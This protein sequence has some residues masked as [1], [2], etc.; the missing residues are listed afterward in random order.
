MTAFL[1]V[2]WCPVTRPVADPPK[3]E[4]ANSANTLYKTL[5]KSQKLP[6]LARYK[7]KGLTDDERKQWDFELG[8]QRDG[9]PALQV[10]PSIYKDP[11]GLK[12]VEAMRQNVKANQAVLE[13]IPEA[14]K[15][16]YVANNN[17]VTTVRGIVHLSIRDGILHA[18]DGDHLGAAT[19][20]LNAAEI[21]IQLQPDVY[22]Y[23]GYSLDLGLKALE[24][25][26]AHL[27]P[28]E[29]RAVAQRLEGLIV[30]R[31]SFAQILKAGYEV[32]KLL[33]NY[34]YSEGGPGEW[35][36][37]VPIL[38]V[39]EHYEVS[40]YKKAMDHNIALAQTNPTQS[41]GFIEADGAVVNTAYTK[42]RYESYQAKVRFAQNV[43]QRLKEPSEEK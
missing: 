40:R 18:M 43:L 8:I 11:D 27:T 29:S 5:E 28:A 25:S 16:P 3:V 13:Q 35:V 36:A 23:G 7:S 24:S 6:F 9:G 12:C 37:R 1:L 33:L 10:L 26:L 38:R 22:T 31:N 14:L 39:I 32:E 19:A 30:R 41:D 15:R 42:K 34:R 2:P 21:G 4:F 20:Y 17:N